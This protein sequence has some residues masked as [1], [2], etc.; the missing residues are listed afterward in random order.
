[1]AACAICGI[2]TGPGKRHLDGCLAR[3]RRSGKSVPYAKR[4]ERGKSGLPQFR[5]PQ[6]F[7]ELCARIVDV[8]LVEPASLLLKNLLRRHTKKDVPE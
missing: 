7:G 1:M 5:L 3:G 4:T 8:G 2:E 6:E